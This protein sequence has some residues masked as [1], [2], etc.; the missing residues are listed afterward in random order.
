MLL[1]TIVVVVVVV[2]FC[3]RSIENGA[4]VRIVYEAIQHLNRVH[5]DDT[6]LYAYSSCTKTPID[7]SVSV[8]VAS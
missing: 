2:D 6:R 7:P 4:D 1:R 8:T 3:C 5:M